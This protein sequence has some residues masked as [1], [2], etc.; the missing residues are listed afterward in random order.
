ME[1][2]Q[3][4]AKDAS[5]GAARRLLKV[6]SD[7]TVE[8]HP[9]RRGDLHLTAEAASTAIFG[10]DSLGRAELLSRLEREFRISLPESLLS[11]SD[12]VADL[13]VGLA[14]TDGVVGFTPDSVIDLS[15]LAPSR[16]TPAEAATLLEVLDRHVENHPDRPHILL[17]DERGDDPEISYRR[18]ADEARA[19]AGALTA[20]G[21]DPGDRIALM[22]PT[23]A[24]FFFASSE[25][26]PPAAYRSRSIRRCGPHN[27]RPSA[28]SDGNS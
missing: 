23:G 10:L 24:D 4:V 14:K 16:T 11:E 28:A 6:V 5:E 8:V 27:S 21:V 3:H 17:W 20:H 2:G 25:F 12:T 22:L 1:Q 19:V 7:F 15:V 18:L 13:L 26:S 9:E